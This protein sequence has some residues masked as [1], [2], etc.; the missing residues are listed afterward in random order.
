MNM[1]AI[2][3]GVG[4]IV[5]AALGS[6]IAMFSFDVFQ[7][8][9]GMILLFVMGIPFIGIILGVIV[10]IKFGNIPFG[11]AAPIARARVQSESPQKSY[12]HEPPPKCPSC[13]ASL[14]MDTVEWIG[15]L[16]LR[17]PYCGASIST[18]KK[19]V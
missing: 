5:A 8:S 17:C 9:I 11:L 14:S 18:V 15:P 2:M 19:E 6:F 4:I 7:M 3:C 12:V 10:M 16:T 1:T 13:N